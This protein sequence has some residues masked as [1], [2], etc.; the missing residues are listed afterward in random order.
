MSILSFDFYQYFEKKNTKQHTAPYVY[1]PNQTTHRYEY[2]VHFQGCLSE[3]CLSVMTPA[4]SRRSEAIRVGVHFKIDRTKRENAVLGVG[5][6][7]SGLVEARSH[8]V[9][10]I[11]ALFF[12]F[13]DSAGQ[14]D[15]RIGHVEV[16]LFI[17]CH[18]IN[19]F[20]IKTF[21]GKLERL[22][23]VCRSGKSFILRMY[24]PAKKYIVCL[25]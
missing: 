17:E 7:L 20:R 15:G 23:I 19:L 5:A 10:R 9:S 16:L 8:I 22:G 6:R 2:I 14:S 13:W 21:C 4:F 25:R 3:L 1:V 12:S 18:I 11:F 24:V